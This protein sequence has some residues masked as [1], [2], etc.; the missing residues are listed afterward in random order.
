MYANRIVLLRYVVDVLSFLFRIAAVSVSYWMCC[1]VVRIKHCL[2]FLVLTISCKY[3]HVSAVQWLIITGFG[4]DYWICERLLLQS[5]IITISLK[6]LTINLQPKT[7]LSRT[8]SIL[9]FVLRFTPATASQ[10]T[11]SALS[12]NSTTRTPWKTL[13]LCCPGMRVYWP[14][15]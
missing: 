12:Y 4:L 5:L 7:W 6:Q 9:I 2:A 10:G 3:C 11:P 14:V 8:R 15:T 1:F 13:L